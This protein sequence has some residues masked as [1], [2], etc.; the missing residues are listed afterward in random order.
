MRGNIIDIPLG[1][2]AYAMSI[3]FSWTGTMALYEKKNVHMIFIQPKV[4]KI[5]TVKLH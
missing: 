5:L 2:I 1:I 3:K 4:L